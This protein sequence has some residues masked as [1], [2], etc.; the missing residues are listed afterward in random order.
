L[1]IT[2]ILNV[3][4]LRCL[5]TL[6]MVSAIVT[7]GSSIH[8]QARSTAP[9]TTGE[10]VMVADINKKPID[11]IPNAGSNPDSLTAVGDALFFTADDDIAG[12]EVWM[13]SPP[14]S[15][16]RMVADIN[17]GSDGSDPRSITALGTTVFFRANDGSSGS[18]LWMTV[19]PYNESSTVRLTEINPNGDS[20][21]MNMKVIGD[22][23]FFSADDGIHGAELFKTEPPYHEARLVADIYPGSQ[24]SSPYEL[25]TMG[26]YLFFIAKGSFGQELWKTSPPYDS[27][28]TRRV[29]DIFPGGNAYPGDLIVIDTTLFFRANDG[30]RGYELWKLAAPYDITTFSIVNGPTKT[31]KNLINPNGSYPGQMTA[32]GDTLFFVANVNLIGSELWKTVPPYNLTSTSRVEDV[33]PLPLPAP[34]NMFN[35]SSD[36]T[37]LTPIGSTLLFSADDGTG[38]HELWRSD[39][40]Y[41]HASS[42][43]EI[44]PGGDGGNPEKFVSLGST[45]IFRANNG[46]DGIELWKIDPPYSKPVQISD[47]NRG[48]GSSLPD[49]ITPLGRNLFF[50][51]SDG[52]HGMELWRVGGNYFAPSTGFEKGVV[53]SRSASLPAAAY[54]EMGGLELEVPRLGVRI[55]IVGVPPSFENWDLS[56]LWDQ[57]G[58]L[59]GTAYPTLPGNTVIT[60][61][62][63][64]ADGSPGPFV[65]LNTLRWG[66]RLIIHAW[67]QDYLYEVRSVIK[68]TPDDP[69][70]F[71]HEDLDWVTLI[72]CQGFDQE[73]GTYLWRVAVRGMLVKVLESK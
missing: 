45:L 12:T 33:N 46:E 22:A 4:I 2:R 5:L 58:Y 30:Q 73:S 21:P 29:L 18:E 64:L 61:H 40:P 37:D 59:E 43:A 19:P 8:A 62:V 47:I 23:L 9:E 67:G 57:A 55:P 6:G 15:S 68:T 71:S 17:P 56:W 41:S 13:T 72:T 3:K 25:T 27:G 63:Y 32:I 39:P 11:A 34:L 70:L 69:A 53:S 35:A 1:P 26:W 49:N 66:D 50:R 14:Y 31:P 38:G 24:D 60:G 54:T 42:L 52:K 51:A 44:L 7:A 65:D 28:S 20:A 48:G 36:P 10:P 16:A